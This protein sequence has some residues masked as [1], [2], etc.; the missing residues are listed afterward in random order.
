MADNVTA[1][2]GAEG[3]G[4]AAGPPFVTEKWIGAPGGDAHVGYGKLVWGL[5]G[6][7]TIVADA[8]GN[9]FP[10]KP[11]GPIGAL[12]D[13]HAA[14]GQGGQDQQLLAPATR[15]LLWIWNPPTETEL[16]YVN[17]GGSAA[18]DASSIPLEPGQWLTMSSPGFVS[19]EAVHVMAATG[20]HKIGCKWA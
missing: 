9:R 3:T 17:F 13:G 2:Q 18:A 11:I 19:N 6:S 12:T 20:G 4:T 8:D 16:L 1:A 5:H 15:R 10:V 14:I 7:F